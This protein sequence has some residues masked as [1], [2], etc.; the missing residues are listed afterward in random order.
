MEIYQLASQRTE[1]RANI[2]QL[3]CIQRRKLKKG[4]FQIRMGSAGSF[5]LNI[6]QIK[7][8]RIEKHANCIGLSFSNLCLP[9]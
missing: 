8:A 2:A 9:S 1:F 4:I 5:S 3:L 6:H 7:F